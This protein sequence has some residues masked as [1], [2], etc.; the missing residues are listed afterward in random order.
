MDPRLLKFYN[1]ELQHLREMGAEFASE[2]PKIAGRLTLDG[3]EC[4]DPYVERLLEG[5]AFLAARVQLR[6]DSEFPRFTQHLFEIVYPHYLAPTPS[7]AVVQFEPDLKVGA[8]A[9]GYTIPRGESIRSLLGKGETTACEY[10]TAQDCTLWP[11]EI[12][13]AEYFSRD[14]ASIE[15]PNVA[16]LKAGIRL[17]IRTTAGLKFKDTKLDRLTLFLRGAGDLPMHLYEQILGNPLGFVV[18]PTTRPIPW[19]VVNEAS[20]IQPRGF[21]ENEALLPYGP[22]SFQGYRLLQEYFAFPQRYLFVDL[23]GLKS[24]VSRCEEQELDIIILLSRAEQRLESYVSAESFSLHCTPAINLFPKSAD[25]IHLSDKF[26]EH[27][28]IPDRTRP[29]DFEVYEVKGIQGYGAEVED[30]QTF[31]PFYASSDVNSGHDGMAYYT[32][33]RLPRVL[34]TNQKK[35]GPRSSYI[36][37]EVFVSLVDGREAPYS[38]NL[39]QLAID[40]LCTNRDLPLQMPVGKST[41]DFTL[42]TGAPVNSVRCLSGPTRPKPSHSFG[43]GDFVWRLISHLSLNYLSLVDGDERHG[44][45]ALRDILRLYGDA[46]DAAIRKQIEGVRSVAARPITRRIPTPGPI[47][48]GRGLEIAITCDEAAFEGSGVFLLG[49]VLEQFFARYVSINSFTETVVHSSDRGTVMRWPTR[50]GRRHTA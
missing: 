14:A 23:T 50:I 49:A 4:V 26:S 16:G 20:K 36:G 8:L 45:A 6:I 35:Y 41:T 7:M 42:D 27:H 46:N 38:H 44:A 37:S 47:T 40:T 25:R 33:H 43:E 29:M 48:F 11:L 15:V 34:S 21:A 32:V 24:A 13:E 2:F 10:R 19:Q 22:R 17:R 12:V 39:R 9:D 5:F 1:R 30:E 18:R 31:F 3:F 28:V